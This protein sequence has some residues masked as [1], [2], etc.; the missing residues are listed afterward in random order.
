MQILTDSPCAAQGIS[1]AGAGHIKQRMDADTSSPF[2]RKKH[3]VGCFLRDGAKKNCFRAPRSEE[4]SLRDDVPQR[5]L[6]LAPTFP[7]YLTPIFSTYS[8]RHQLL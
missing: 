5:G 7:L 4:G 3:P 8:S 2:Q 6:E 1:A